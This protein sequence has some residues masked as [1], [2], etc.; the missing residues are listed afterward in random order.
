M[1]TAFSTTSFSTT[2]FSKDA[3][4]IATQA[5]GGQC[6]WGTSWSRTWGP[7]WG[8][9]GAPEQDGRSGY[10]RLFFTNLQ[11]EALKPKPETTKPQETVLE[12]EQGQEAPA[13]KSKAKTR[14]PAVVA[15]EQF[16][17]VRFKRKPIYSDA[18]PVVEDFPLWLAEVSL[19]VDQWISSYIPLWNEH[20]QVIISRKKEAANDADIRLCL[21]LLAA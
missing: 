18:K 17:E 16:P 1:A 8:C 7:S 10:W 11:E 12:Q 5:V 20:R 19:E 6:S 4:S 15:V 9:G 13:R 3:Y 14:K 21:L 2:S